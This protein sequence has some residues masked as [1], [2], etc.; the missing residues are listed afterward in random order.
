MAR[1]AE[2]THQTKPNDR[3]NNDKETSLTNDDTSFQYKDHF[4][5][6]IK[7]ALN[8]VQILDI[9]WRQVEF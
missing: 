4:K 3:H 2:T 9:F 8:S 7:T 6:S 5:Q 1:K